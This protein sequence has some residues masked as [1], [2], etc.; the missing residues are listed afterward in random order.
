MARCKVMQVEKV[1]DIWGT[2]STGTPKMEY[3]YWGTGTP[4]VLLGYPKK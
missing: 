4:R 2:L 3:P 1:T